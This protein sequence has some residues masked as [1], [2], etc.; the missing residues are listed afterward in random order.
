[1]SW[2]RSPL[3]VC[4]IALIAAVLFAERLSPDRGLSLLGL[5][6]PSRRPS[7]PEATMAAPALKMLRVPAQGK[8]T[9]TVLFLHGLGDTG[10]GWVRL[11]CRAHA[12]RAVLPRRHSG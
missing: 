12:E 11:R 3:F 10:M 7:S 6:K 2:S 1:M 5:V 9:A 4:A 8:H